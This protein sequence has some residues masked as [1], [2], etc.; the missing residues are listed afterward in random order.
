MTYGVLPY[1]KTLRN[2]KKCFLQRQPPEVFEH[3]F[4]RIP[5]DDCF[6]YYSDRGDELTLVLASCIIKRYNSIHE[7][8]VLYYQAVDLHNLIYLF[9]DVIQFRAA[10]SRS[11]YLFFFFFVLISF[12]SEN[13]M[14]FISEKPMLCL[15]HNFTA[16]SHH[17][18]S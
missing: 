12:I 16:H 11:S 9:C 7:H 8:L 18:F 14:S 17:I 3:F 4:Y 5:P 15:L 1:G 2:I 13:P 6:C 10:V